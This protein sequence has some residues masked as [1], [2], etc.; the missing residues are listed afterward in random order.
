MRRCDPKLHEKDAGYGVC[1]QRRRD[2]K[3]C[4]EEG[5]DDTMKKFTCDK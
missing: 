3:L 5:S 4:D 1:G 2:K